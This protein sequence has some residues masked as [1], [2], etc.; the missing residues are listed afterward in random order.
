VNLP[1]ALVLLGGLQSLVLVAYLLW[2]GR[3]GGPVREG[4]GLPDREQR[5]RFLVW[6]SLYVNP[7]DPR[8][9]VEKSSGVGWTVNF[10][11]RGRARVFVLM[12]ANALLLAG[13][14]SCWLVY[15]LF[16]TRSP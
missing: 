3:G 12:A 14:G 5:R 1:A 16:G 13:A 7:D 9:W 10:R 8:G 11:T 4:P 6:R 2:V 15:A